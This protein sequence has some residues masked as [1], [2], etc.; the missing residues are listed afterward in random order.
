[1][2]DVRSRVLGWWQQALDMLDIPTRPTATGPSPSAADEPFLPLLNEPV[3]PDRH[4]VIEG[5]PIWQVAPKTRRAG[6]RGEHWAPR[7]EHT[8][9]MPAVRS[10]DPVPTRLQVLRRPGWPE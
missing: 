5:R 7:T 4:A 10:D 9:L 3:A 8:K 6:E 1:M 2:G